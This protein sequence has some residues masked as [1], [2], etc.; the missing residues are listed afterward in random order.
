MKRFAALHDWPVLSRRAVDR[1]LHRRV[2]V[3]GREQDERVGS[4]ELERDLL[5]V[6]AGDLG[7][8]GTGPLRSGD[9][10]ALH[11]P[12]GDHRRRLVIG[13]VDVRVRALGEAGIP[14]DLLDRGGGLG[15]LRSVLEQD[16]VADARGSARRSGRPGSTGSSTA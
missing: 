9:R 6:A 8:R 3:V 14:V 16:R 1:G 15:A 5:Q 2:E 13:R 10:H 7:D 11:A 12:V 4:A